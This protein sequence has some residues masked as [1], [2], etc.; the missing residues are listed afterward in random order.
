MFVCEKKTFK[1]VSFSW[2]SVYKAPLCSIGGTV[3]LVLR[4]INDF[5]IVNQSLVEIKPHF[6]L[7]EIWAVCVCF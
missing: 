4:E 1:R 2:S 7:F 6:N 3:D 5:K